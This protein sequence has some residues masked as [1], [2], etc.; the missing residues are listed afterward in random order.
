MALLREKS[1]HGGYPDTGLSR[2]A[3]GKLYI[4]TT[5]GWQAA[6][7]TWAARAGL[8]N[9]CNRL[10]WPTCCRSG[11]QCRE[12][13]I[14]QRYIDDLIRISPGSK[15]LYYEKIFNRQLA[16]RRLG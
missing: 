8:H 13:E 1:K 10:H 12:L 15:I 11:R 9:V 3:A 5:T 16:S 4:P 2:D 14:E 6:A 7:T